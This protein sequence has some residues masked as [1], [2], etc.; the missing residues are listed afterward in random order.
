MERTKLR[1]AATGLVLASVLV[2]SAC[3]EKEPV[4]IGFI[5][6]ITGRVAD[7]GVSGRNAVQ[8]AVDQANQRGGIDGRKIELVI[9]DDEQS[10]EVARKRFKELLD[11]RVG[12]VIGPMTSAMC[13]AVL[14]QANE[15]KL[16][17]MAPTCT[18]NEFAGKD[19]F[20]LRVVS[21]AKTY[22]EISARYQAEVLG[23]RRVALIHD[24]RNK[25][26]SESWANDYAA[27]FERVGGKV[28]SSRAFTSGDD[29]GL[30]GM[31][32]E[33]FK[34]GPDV[35]V[36]VANSVDAALLTQHLRRR[37][38]S[39]KIAT[40]EWA[41]T[42][43][44]IELAG[45]AAE[46]VV[47]PQFFDRESTVASFVEFRKQYRER[48]GQEPGIGGVTAFDAANIVIEAISRHPR[49]TPREAVMAI[50]KFQGVQSPVDFDASGDAQ[51]DSYVTIIRDGRFA[52]VAR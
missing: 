42:E 22:A 32:E 24:A 18:A 35:V 9:R 11:A 25:A 28:V 39:V 33:A 8:L 43:R 7:L 34:A 45:K 41:S 4:R 14:P 31:A 40:A 19:D 15:H 44:Y 37:S 29:A 10:V 17:V 46:G 20:F 6:G 2:L 5:A 12:L 52:I 27:A 23:S 36:L 30:G 47:V 21:S 48:F 3:G 1:R 50:R 51:R 26:Y 38:A 49:L 13:L 16:M